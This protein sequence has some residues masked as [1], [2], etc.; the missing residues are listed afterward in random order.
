MVIMEWNS[1][2]MVRCSCGVLLSPRAEV[3]IHLQCSR[4]KACSKVTRNCQQLKILCL[5]EKKKDTMLQLTK[6]LLQDGG[7]VCCGGE[8]GLSPGSI[9]ETRRRVTPS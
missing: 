5:K 3:G 6:P 8:C 7:D 4:N 1:D 2:H 9:S